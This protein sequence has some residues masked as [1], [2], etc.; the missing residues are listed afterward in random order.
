VE[1][2]RTYNAGDMNSIAAL[3]AFYQKNQRMPSFGELAKLLGFKSKWGA[4]LAVR[5]WLK[6]GLIRKDGKGMFSVRVLGTV[7][8]GWPSPAEEENVDSISL[9]EWLVTNKEATFMLKVSGDSMVDAGIMPG[10]MV[11]L[12]RGK[13]PRHKDIVVAEVDREW[14]I[15]YFYKKGE[16]VALVPANKKYKPI[17]PKEELKI[18]GVVTAVIRKY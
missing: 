9:D 6:Q 17:V 13:Q 8:A 10:D 7:A 5:K 18:A 15:K 2:E 3:K 16:K 4:Q 14:T 1:Y 12:E 11:I